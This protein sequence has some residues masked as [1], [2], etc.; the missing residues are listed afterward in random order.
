MSDIY[1]NRYFEWQESDIATQEPDWDELEKQGKVELKY[2]LCEE[3]LN[4]FI[5]QL[6]KGGAQ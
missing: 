6:V 1:M 3:K 2:P 5:K 4:E